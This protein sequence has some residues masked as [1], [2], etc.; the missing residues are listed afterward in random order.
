MAY[1]HHETRIK[2]KYK[3]QSLI[4]VARWFFAVAFECTFMYTSIDSK[5]LKSINISESNQQHAKP[6]IEHSILVEIHRDRQL[7]I[8]FQEKTISQFFESP[9][10]ELPILD[11]RLSI[12]KKTKQNSKTNMYSWPLTNSEK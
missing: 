2:G 12:N 10:L 6:L 5:N 9:G 1:V 8:A 4:F 11:L 3:E 7:H